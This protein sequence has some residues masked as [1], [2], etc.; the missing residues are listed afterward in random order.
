MYKNRT[1]EFSVFF[2]L[3][4]FLFVH[5]FWGFGGHFGWDDMEYAQLAH[6]WANGTFHIS[7]NHFSY[8][9]PVILFTGIAY[10][11]FGVNDFSSALPALIIS[12]LI[13][14]I[15][16]KLLFHRDSRIIITAFVIT[17]LMPSFLFYSDKLMSDMYVA[18]GVLV[19]FYAI[20]TSR[21]IDKR[22]V[23]LYAL[24][25]VVG[26][27]FAFVTKEVV[28]LVA[29]AF[30]ILFIYDIVKRQYKLFWIYSIVL[31]IGILILYHIFIAYKTGSFF[32]RYQAIEMNAY[33]NPCSYEFLPWINT[34]KRIGYELW[35]EFTLNSILLLTIFFIPT[36][37]KKRYWTFSKPDSLW[38]LI[39]FILLLSANFMTKSYKGY[40]PMC[41]DIRHYLYLIP[42]LAITV[43]PLIVRYFYSFRKSWLTAILIFLLIIWFS[44]N[45]KLVNLKSIYFFY[46][47]I[48]I[49]LVLSKFVH[50]IRY[51]NIVWS[52][53][54]LLW[55]ITPLTQMFYD[56]H[57]G[58]NQIKPFIE[59]HF[60]NA[61]QTAIVLTDPVMKR[62]A[63]YMM[64]WDS[65]KVRFVNERSSIIPYRDEAQQYFV[66]HNG[67][68]W[69]LT[70]IYKG[71]PM[72]MWNF[73]E[74]YIRR[75]DSIAGNELY[76]V[77][78]AEKMNRPV[79]FFQYFNDLE[80]VYIPHFNSNPN[81]VDSTKHYS[82]KKSFRLEPQGF[83]PTLTLPV[84]SFSSHRTTKIEV[85]IKAHVWA[86]NNK[87]TSLV[88]SIEDSSN[89]PIFWI[90][91]PIKE[92]I[93][94][95]KCWQSVKLNASYE[96]K[97]ETIRQILKLYLWN[98]DTTTI[99]VDDIAIRIENI[100]HL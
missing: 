41:I 23:L 35:F 99:W 49:L 69:W 56:Y 91:K 54:L 87:L 34:L 58:Y 10:K 26:L 29:P 50:T 3:I 37:L 66:Y 72:I 94:P 11:W 24:V 93:K 68:T 7:E 15:V 43:S 88:M 27:F 100:E 44:I 28:V 47:G 13:L 52:V 14:L 57:N 1:V 65:S 70:G 83:S 38:I 59:K 21:F 98:D 71:G 16:Y 36:L 77:V 46:G 53:F 55:L 74:P 63:D 30:I 51:K 9:F 45:Y 95:C 20:F 80:W 90:G 6:Q 19:S 62:I 78:Y 75:M 97:P 82:G 96:M 22:R 73:K 86:E 85:Q 12:I 18:L 2:S 39:T 32:S 76:S 33:L 79:S 64:Q 8:R 4:I 5:H 25:F 81:F 84:S 60:K 61:E 42:I 92:I 89:K 17:A 31:G 40:S 48:F 67:L